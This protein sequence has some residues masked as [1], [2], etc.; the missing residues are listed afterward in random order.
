MDGLNTLFIGIY[1][2]F[3]LLVLL[4]ALVFIWGY[5]ALYKSMRNNLDQAEQ[6]QMSRV[7]TVISL[8]GMA[9]LIVAAVF[10]YSNINAFTGAFPRP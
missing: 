1:C 8:S 9:L 4:L 2:L 3:G 6:K 5:I 7:F 10:A